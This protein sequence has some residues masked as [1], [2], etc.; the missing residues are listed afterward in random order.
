VKSSIEVTLGHQMIVRADIFDAA[1]IH[2]DN[3]V[4]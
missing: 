4:G 2:H 3:A 1:V